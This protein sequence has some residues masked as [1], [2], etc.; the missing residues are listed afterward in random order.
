VEWMYLF[1]SAFISNIEEQ[2]CE[3]SFESLSQK[4]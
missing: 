4:I 3:I 2:N 1:T